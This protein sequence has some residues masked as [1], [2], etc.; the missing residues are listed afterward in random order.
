MTGQ[1]K[2]ESCLHRS[3][4]KHPKSSRLARALSLEP[5]YAS[6]HPS[7]LLIKLYLP[8]YFLLNFKELLNSFF[9]ADKSQGPAPR[10]Y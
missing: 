10:H 2:L 4:L 5:T 8:H 6:L 3:D 1:M 9:K 7:S